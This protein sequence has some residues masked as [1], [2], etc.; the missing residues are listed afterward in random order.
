MGYVK[1]TLLNEYRAQTRGG[2]GS[3]GSSVRSEDFVEHIFMCTNHNYLLFFTEKGRCYW[4]RAFEV[5]EGE[6]NSKGRPI[7]NMINI[8]PDDK[9]KAFVN[10]SNLSDEEYLKNHFIVMCTIARSLF[11]PTYQRYY[12]CGHPRRRRSHHRMPH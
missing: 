1:R 10:V 4:M 9:V 2:V 5:P 12:R 7:L 6:K 3:K 11:T 8:E